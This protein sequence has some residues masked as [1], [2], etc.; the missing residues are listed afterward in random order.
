MVRGSRFAVR[1]LLLAA[2]AGNAAAAEDMFKPNVRYSTYRGPGIEVHVPSAHA[3]A[4]RP[5]AERA[6]ALYARMAADAGYT[7]TR[8]LHLVLS[9]DEDMHNGFSTVVPFPLVN[10]QLGPTRPESGLFAGADE[11]F[12]TMVHEFGHDLSN[13]RNHG[14]RGVLEAVFGRVM[15]SEP[16]SLGVFLL[17]TP[18]HVLSPGFWHEGVAQW[19]ETA[20]ADPTSAWGGRGRDSLNHMLWRLDAAAGGVPPADEWRL[21]YERWPYGN[22]AYLYG[23]AYTRWLSGAF[24][25]R[26]GLW[27]VVEDQ[28]RL[29]TP[30][31]FVA[32]AE[33]SLGWNHDRLIPRARTALQ[34]EQEEALA[35]LRT[36]P[37]TV[38]PRLTPRQWRVA[39]PAW[40]DDGT[41]V[42]A[43]DSPTAQP[44]LYV[45]GADGSDRCGA[46]A[47]LLG[48][49]RRIDGEHLVYADADIGGDRWQRSRV[50]IL[51]QSGAVL[52]E[53]DHDRLIQPDARRQGEDF[54]VLAIRLEGAGAQSL[55]RIPV[56]GEAV[57]IASEGR[58]WS[59]AFRPGH[60]DLCWVETDKTGSRL[61]VDDLA[62]GAR[63]VLWAVR[64]RILHPVW[65]PDGTAI[66]CASDVSG[67]ANGW[68]V[69]LTGEPRPVSNVI[70]GVLA[71]VP[72]PDGRRL[73]VLDHD[74]EGPYIGIIPLDET[75]WP[76][77]LPRLDLPWPAP[78]AR[79][80]LGPE[81]VGD[82]RADPRPVGLEPS[83]LPAAEPYSGLAGLRPYYWTPTTLVVPEGGFGAVAVAHDPL[84]THTV[85]ASAGVGYHEHSPVGLFAWTYQG[86]NP[87]LGFIAKRAEN[88]YDQQ[89]VA[90]DFNFYDYSETVDTVE[91]RI[92][93]GLGGY[94]RRWQVWLAAGLDDYES[95]ESAED[96]YAGLTTFGP[97]PFEGSER[98]VEAVLAYDDS[99]LFPT[100]YAREDGAQLAASYRVGDERG[101][102]A[103]AIGSYALSV[104]PDWNHQ[105]VVAGQLGWSDGPVDLQGRFGIGGN[106]AIGVPRGYP[107]TMVRGRTLEALS[108]AYRLPLWQPFAGL[109]TTPWVTR[110]VVVEGFYDTAR[111]S[112]RLGDPENAGDWYRSAGGEVHLE[113]EFWLARFSP[114][115][116]VARQIDGLEDTVTYFALDF[117]W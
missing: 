54:E 50:R 4:L 63:R 109:G 1:G 32:G 47:W 107:Q 6:V 116:G 28:G 5:L 7:P 115:L 52:R 26:R 92:G 95:V 84:M 11:P 34:L 73:A 75:A 9:D 58:P 76:T 82:D 40:R 65:A 24:G 13:D 23:L 41:L 74:A 80:E 101:S 117:R 33:G 15:P 61:V 17:S 108:G 42:H 97:K 21:A 25:D 96:D 57:A 62:G 29:A 114:G 87:D 14:W 110:Q 18:N 70:G 66:F 93:Y 102:R 94:G 78:V 16:L 89:V 8:T 49:V 37:V 100:S 51:R 43:G 60:D 91:G 68:R 79:A 10:V 31:A 67:V 113:I 85:I 83:P 53:L 88:G 99:M 36:Q 112:D 56:A 71:V 30:F 46:S 103:I 44:H 98:Y 86:W 64:G 111:V 55:V 38:V 12:R 20:Y 35:A 48:N 90:S 59:P 69:P 45:S 27:R 2:L 22:R 39:A 3:D 106:R 77:Q 72:S 81:A 105:I 19:A 104:I